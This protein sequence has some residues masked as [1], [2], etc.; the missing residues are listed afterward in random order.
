[1]V[2]KYEIHDLAYLVPMASEAEQVVLNEDIR[3]NGLQTPIVLWQGKIIDGRCRQIACIACGERIRVTTLDDS[4][5]E[6]EI[7]VVV[8]SLNIRRNLTLTQKIVSAAYEKIKRGNSISA[9]KLAASWGI[10][11]SI[12]NN[13][14]YIVK[15]HPNEAKLLFNGH[16]I[17]I[18]GKGGKNIT[19]SRISAI[20]NYYVKIDETKKMPNSGQQ[21]FGYVTDAVLKTQHAKEH[22][23]WLMHAC[24]LDKNNLMQIDLAVKA[25]NLAYPKADGVVTEIQ[26]AVTSEADKNIEF[27]ETLTNESVKQ[28]FI[29]VL[30]ANPDLTQVSRDSALRM[31]EIMSKQVVAEETPIVEEPNIC[32]LCNDKDDNCPLCGI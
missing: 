6:D 23:V 1:M 10:S 9:E 17:P 2:E 12:L 26:E 16:A 19:S 11:R 13:A 22:F 20:F 25:A 24:G 4:L 31:Q 7:A 8:K 28:Q 30:R 21:Q 14:L 5:S 15:N 18:V 29:S 3:V 27:I 32:E